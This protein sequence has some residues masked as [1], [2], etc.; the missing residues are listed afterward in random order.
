[1][2]RTNAD[3]FLYYARQYYDVLGKKRERHVAGPISHQDADQKAEDLQ[4]QIE[5][6]KG[7]VRE[8]RLLG[9]EG[10]QV[11]D[12][13]TYSTLATLHNH[14]FFRAGGVLVGSHAFG[15]MLNHLGVRA[16]AYK[17]EDVD[18]AKFTLDFNPPP[19]LTFFEM[20]KESGIPFVEIP[21][22][23]HKDP[24]TQWKEK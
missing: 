1:M 8:I 19:V 15:V 9:R 2:K 21:P 17:P 23:H 22:F 5:E 4:T 20:L 12:P 13:R 24:I 18:L 14:D 16:G 10:Y 7:I 6:L 11:V 3:Q